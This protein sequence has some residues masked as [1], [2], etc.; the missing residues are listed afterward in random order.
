MSREEAKERILAH[1]N[2]VKQL[3][4]GDLLVWAAGQKID[5]ADILAYELGQAGKIFVDH[6]SATHFAV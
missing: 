4:F 6:R 3:S 2:S 1:V 5:Y